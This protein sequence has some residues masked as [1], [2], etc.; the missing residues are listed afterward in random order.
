M[1]GYSNYTLSKHTALAGLGCHRALWWLLHEPSAPERVAT[2]ADE[3]RQRE[4]RRVGALARS[5]VPGGR[6]I[7]GEWGDV[8]GRVARTRDAMADP[9]VPAIYEAAFIAHDTLVY[10]D[11]LERRG[12]AWTLVEVKSSTSLS[13]AE[14]VPDIAIQASV[15]RACGVAVERY[16]IMHLNRECQFP[17][18]S[19]LFVRDDVTETVRNASTRSISRSPSSSSWRA[20]HR[21]RRYRLVN[22]AQ[23]RA[24]ARSSL[25]VGRCCR[26]I[27]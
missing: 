24:T 15:L 6:L 23:S 5:Y 9:A 1:T 16:E 17:D 27:T 20:R 4:G 25:A 13:E 14:H 8:A 2:P 22:S 11:I 18:L 10:V 26:R 7:D 21:R 3:H 12:A 19:T